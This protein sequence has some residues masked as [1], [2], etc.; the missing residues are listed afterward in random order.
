MTDPAPIDCDVHPVVP[1][2]A[3][4]LPYMDAHWRETV[5]RRGIEG[6]TTIS[7]PTRNPLSFR[8]DWRD[9]TGRTATDAATLG[10]QGLARSGPRRRNYDWLGGVKARFE[11]E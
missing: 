5:V 4:L 1:E 2:L 8:H 6:L 9:E 10:R 11:E 7:Y 3:A